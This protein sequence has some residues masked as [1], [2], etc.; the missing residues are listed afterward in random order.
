V[1]VRIRNEILALRE[2]QNAYLAGEDSHYQLDGINFVCWVPT[3]PER[4]EVA[5]VRNDG[6]QLAGGGVDQV[7]T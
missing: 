7:E 3:L 4:E 1:E 2:Q 5:W 6:P